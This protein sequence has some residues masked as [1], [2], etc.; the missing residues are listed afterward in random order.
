MSRDLKLLA[1]ALFTW[2]IGEGMFFIFQPI[3]LQ[4][5]GASPVLI[6]FVI[7][8]MGAAMAIAQIPAG[9]LADR[10][11]GRALMR[12]AWVIG[13]AATMIMGLAS[14]MNIFIAGML[15]YGLT[16]FVTAP[17][18]SYIAS[19]RGKWS[20]E[21]AITFGSAMF[22][23]GAISGPI[24]GGILGQRFGL[25]AVYLIAA[26]IFVISCATMFLVSPQ[27]V[28]SH[29][30]TASKGKLHR[31]GP[32][33][34]FLVLSFFT[35]LATTLPQPLTPNFLQN[36]RSLSLE[37]IGQMGSLASLGSVIFSFTLGNLSGVNGFL[38]GQLAVGLFTLIL[39]RGN[40]I[41]WIS[42]SYLLLGGYRLMRNMG[43]AYSRSLIHTADTGLA[44]G[45]VETVNAFAIILAPALAGF[46]Y[47]SN[48]L[49]VYTISLVM[50]A[51]MLF[52]NLA[53]LTP[54]FKILPK[55]RTFFRMED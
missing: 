54:Y 39:W 35:V 34:T 28:E 6:G 24:L 38:V 51:G 41:I 3:Y 15:I 33:I 50:I 45:V 20:I 47:N 25:K 12:A 21:R 13:L 9:Y 40:N 16:A 8:G 31:N 5:W 19:A 1:V 52:I 29:H 36:Q 17:L 22:Q 53:L 42:L 10:L 55:L 26:A 18:N 48:P 4:Q 49:S 27:L 30:E 2:G 11:G 44:F 23:M 7:G 14:S 32:F 43:L 46:I 37:T